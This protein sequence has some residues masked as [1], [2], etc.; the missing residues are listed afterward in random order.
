MDG[1]AT[2]NISEADDVMRLLRKQAQ[3]YGRLATYSGRQRRLVSDDDI[4]TL[5]TLLADR[6]RLS[7]ELTHVA[8]RL[9]PI[10]HNWSTFRSHLTQDQRKEAEALIDDAERQLRQVME[11]DERDAH[12][13]AGRKRLAADALQTAHQDGKALAAYRGADASGRRL[14]CSEGA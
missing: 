14:D 9:A 2:T 6:Q 4:G 8:S 5:L 7:Q 10:R 11:E 3:L 1:T 12:V 13:L